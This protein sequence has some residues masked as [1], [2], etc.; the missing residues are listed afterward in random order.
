M[1]DQLATAGD[2]GGHDG[3]ITRG[4]R[5]TGNTARLAG[6]LYLLAGLPG[7]F[8]MMYVAR[9]L[10]V[11]GD[12]AATGQKILGSEMLFRAGMA[13]ELISA[14]FLLYVAIILYRLFRKV[15]AT[16]ARL[17]V[18]LA[19]AS[20]PI[21]F[22]NILNDLAALTLLRGATFLSAFE[23]QQRNALA[24]LFLGLHHQ[25][26]FLNQV[27]WGLWLLPLGLLVVQSRS[28]PRIIGF[29]LIAACVGYVGSSL[30]W[31]LLPSYAAV[32]NQIG[33]ALE[34]LGETAF[35]AWLL[36]RGA[37]VERLLNPTP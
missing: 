13:A 35:V 34:G 2:A 18:T 12:P 22:L 26:F 7:A 25:G 29:L 36:I 9:A 27:F 28:L 5:W 1:T 6:A 23:P 21:S 33:L 30:V 15:N 11:P 31:L 8:S 14:V 3:S 20:V 10:T 4:A 19:L 24:T 16:Q 17:M 37:D 32:G